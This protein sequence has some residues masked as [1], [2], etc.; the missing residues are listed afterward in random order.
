ML[1]IVFGKLIENG[2]DVNRNASRFRTVSFQR[3]QLAMA[4][5]L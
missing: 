3:Q 1:T 5:P 2:F 4:V